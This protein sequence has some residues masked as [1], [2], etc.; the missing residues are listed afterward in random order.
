[1]RRA[2]QQIAIY[3]LILA[4][5]ALGCGGS[6]P[7]PAA[8]GTPSSDSPSSDSPEAILGSSSE[9]AAD[10]A[11]FSKGVAAIKAE[12][13]DEAR[14]IFEKVTHD[15]P[16]NAQAHYYLGVALQSLGQAPSA[17]ASYE[18][19]VGLDPKLTEAW[20]N[21][22][23]AKLD[24]GDAAG[25]LPLVERALKA[26][27]DHPGLLYNHALALAAVG[28][29]P[30][31]TVA[32]YRKASAAD[33]ANLEIKYGYAEALVAAGS[34]EPALT[35][36]EELSRSDQL[37][38]LASAGRLLGRLEAWD[39]CIRTL[40]KAL[41]KQPSAE[42]LVTRGLCKHGKKDEPAALED[43][44]QAV[45]ADPKYAPAHYY[46]GMHLKIAGKKAQARTEFAKAVELAGDQGV[47][48]AAKHALE[49]L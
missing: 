22:T 32:A 25:A 37:E 19:A 21:L 1:V 5:L 7:A 24:A 14:A 36:L 41:A 42:L 2:T 39:S 27:P 3:T 28:G 12:K 16:K 13:Y 8:P 46:V 40:D 48:K 45:K 38:V 9:P 31:E 30:T 49:T 26:H 6:S 11:Q 43:F 23:A 29:H 47:G 17:C 10:S 18:K 35:L 15:E 33:P 44:Q 20:V 34:K 4:G